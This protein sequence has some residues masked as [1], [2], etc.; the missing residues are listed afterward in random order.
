MGKH[1]YY[2]HHLSDDVVVSQKQDYRIPDNYSIL[3]Q[4]LGGKIWS[5]I[6][7]PI[8][9]LVSFI[10]IRLILRIKIVGKEK[11]RSVN[12]DGFFI[13]GNH[14]QAFGD[15]V[16][17]LSIIPS[18]KYYAIGAQANWGIPILGKL[19][20]PYFGLPVGYNLQQ[21]GKL[22]KAVNTIIKAKK[23]VVIYPEAHVWPYYTKIRPFSEASMHFPIMLNKCSFVMTTT[24]TKPRWGQRPRITVYLD[25]P[26]YPDL[27][28]EK[29]QAQKKLHDQIVATM[30]KRAAVSNYKYYTYQKII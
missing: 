6:V 8:G 11:L 4:T 25:G 7:R 27:H 29:K 9:H 13:Y 2:Y 3:P 28:M 20:M 10:Y 16:L 30:E 24:Y 1:K 5:A 12:K 15:V 22:V 23:V 18:K 14:T 26:F 21:S 19:I 17:P